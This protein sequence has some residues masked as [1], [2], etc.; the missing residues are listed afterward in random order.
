VLVHAHGGTQRDAPKVLGGMT[1]AQ[2]RWI[3]SGKLRLARKWLPWPQRWS[4]YAVAAVVRPLVLVLR[5]RRV[6]FLRAYYAGWRK[7]FR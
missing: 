7:Q 3:A 6:G 5:F 1:A 4:A 2:V